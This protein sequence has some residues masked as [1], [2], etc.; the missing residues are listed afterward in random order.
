MRRVDVAQWP[1]LSI[2]KCAALQTRC[3]S[4][5]DTHSYYTAFWIKV[6]FEKIYQFALLR[7]NR[8]ILLICIAQGL[9]IVLGFI[10]LHNPGD[11]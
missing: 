6:M 10:L 4:K 1:P 9:I 5:R 11:L 8:P 2:P 3:R 7:K